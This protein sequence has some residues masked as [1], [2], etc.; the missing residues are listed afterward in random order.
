MTE[1]EMDYKTALDHA[2]SYHSKMVKPFEKLAEV[3]RAAV[4][5][6]ANLV[7]MVRERDT[8]A[9]QLKD[10]VATFATQH[11]VLTTELQ[12]A[13]TGAA[14]LLAALNEQV[15]HAQAETS[16]TLLR[17]GDEVR[18]AQS[19]HD[20]TLV[21]LANER[22]ESERA[23]RELLDTLRVTYAKEQAEYEAFRK[24]IGVA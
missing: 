12:T 18:Q 9:T 20:D 5:A 3:L 7:L 13:K 11:E 21:S 1:P 14:S 4:K 8:A 6:E 23:T 17:L 15:R 22:G 16:A 2:A 10:L 19:V 24:R